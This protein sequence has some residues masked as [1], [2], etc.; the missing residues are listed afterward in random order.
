MYIGYINTPSCVPTCLYASPQHHETTAH[1]CVLVESNNALLSPLKRVSDEVTTSVQT[2]TLYPAV[3]GQR[4]PLHVLLT[5][6]LFTAECQN[7]DRS[8]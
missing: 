3:A 2:S 5:E 6:T 7:I 8:M 1:W 4:A